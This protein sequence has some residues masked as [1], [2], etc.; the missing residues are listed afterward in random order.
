MNIFYSQYSVIS[1]HLLHYSQ[2][3]LSILPFSPA[4][5]VS[6]FLSRTLGLVR[7][8]P[9]LNLM[10]AGQPDF[11]RRDGGS[12]S[13]PSVVPSLNTFLRRQP[14]RASSVPLPNNTGVIA[15]S[16]NNNNDGHDVLMCPDDVAP[17]LSDY[18]D[19]DYANDASLDMRRP[20]VLSDSQ[21]RLR[22]FTLPVLIL[23]LQS[24]RVASESTSQT[25][26]SSSSNSSSSSSSTPSTSSRSQNGDGSRRDKR[27][28][29][30]G[31]LSLE[32]RSDCGLWW[33]LYHDQPPGLLQATEKGTRRFGCPILFY[34]G[35]G[36]N[37]VLEHFSN[38]IFFLFSV[39]VFLYFLVIF[40]LFSS[41][42]GRS[43]FVLFLGGT[44][45]V[46]SAQTSFPLETLRDCLG[47]LRHRTYHATRWAGW[48]FTETILN[49][50]CPNVAHHVL[51][52]P[53]SETLMT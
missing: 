28:D 30:I 35:L 37:I 50:C 45:V 17:T 27:W 16:N 46:V 31:F 19:A 42:P 38:P 1:S 7:P 41:F 5:Q 21:I 6:A 8:P 15:A 2:R 44:D 14:A 39:H 36:Y 9:P 25:P 12:L 23:H 33:H 48:E 26:N 10:A 53:I 34:S 32:F 18:Y 47:E 13:I 22:Y 24:L 43:L 29:T 11:L 40:S 52:L 20:L 51:D 49:Q 4:A 3:L